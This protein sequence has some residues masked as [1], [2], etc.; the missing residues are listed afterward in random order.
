MADLSIALQRDVS[1]AY[2]KDDGKAFT[3]S[4]VRFLSLAEDLD[5]LLATRQELLLGAWISAAKRWATND[6]E[7]RP[8]EQ[9]ARQ[10]VTTW[11]PSGPDALLFEYSNHQ[12]S[13]PIRGY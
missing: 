12:W 6:A 1:D 11:G 5:G 10:L 8:Y 13:G 4:S 3:D 9:N 2:R 7:R